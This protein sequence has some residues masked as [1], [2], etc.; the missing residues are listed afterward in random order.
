M[1]QQAGRKSITVHTHNKNKRSSK[2]SQSNNPDQQ[3][4]FPIVPKKNNR[5]HTF[6]ATTE[7]SLHMH[8]FRTEQLNLDAGSSLDRQHITDTEMDVVRAECAVAAVETSHSVVAAAAANV[9]THRAVTAA[10]AAAVAD[11]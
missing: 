10:A 4:I 3:T 11:E 2:N 7:P 6:I 5:L 8:A 9:D 1:R